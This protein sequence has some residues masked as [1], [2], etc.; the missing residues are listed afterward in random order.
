MQPPRDS[1]MTFGAYNISKMLRFH[2]GSCANHIL[3]KSIARAEKF[4][5]R[6]QCSARILCKGFCKNQLEISCSNFC[7]IL[8]F[9]CEK[10]FSVAHSVFFTIFDIDIRK[11]KTNGAGWFI[12]SQ[13]TLAIFN[14]ASCNRSQFC[15]KFWSAEWWSHFLENITFKFNIW[16]YLIKCVSSWFT[17]NHLKSKISSSFSPILCFCS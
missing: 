6:I 1:P 9:S 12:S 13:D 10:K 7:I 15:L 2:T 8:K 5:V 4:Y 3:E 17:S 16:I 14:N 11:S